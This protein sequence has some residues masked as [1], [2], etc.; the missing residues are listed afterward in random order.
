MFVATWAIYA[1]EP[2]AAPI[3]LR[4]HHEPLVVFTLSVW[5]WLSYNRLV[6]DVAMIHTETPVPLPTL[7]KPKIFL[8]VLETRA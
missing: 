4:R 6:K 3:C 2:K 7:Y 8:T 5:H 1:I